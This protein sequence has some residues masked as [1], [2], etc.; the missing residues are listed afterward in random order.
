MKVEYGL[1]LTASIGY[2][3][4]SGVSSSEILLPSLSVPGV[5]DF[6]IH[7]QMEPLF[8]NSYAISPDDFITSFQFGLTGG[9]DNP[10]GDG[11]L[12]AYSDGELNA[13]RDRRRS[14]RQPNGSLLCQRQRHDRGSAFR[15][16]VV[17]Q[18]RLRHRRD[19]QRC[20]PVVGLQ[21]AATNQ[22]FV[23][24]RH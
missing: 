7:R 2:E 20:V 17:R 24:I 8:T 21:R 14:G 1:A 22:H 10:T 5:S 15:R 9:V 16:R 11:N 23:R 18:S 4:R 19:R 12:H 3:V 6:G 13:G